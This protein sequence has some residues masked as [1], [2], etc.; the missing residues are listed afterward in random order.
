MTTQHTPTQKAAIVLGKRIDKGVM[1][2]NGNADWNESTKIAIRACNAHDEL[3]EALDAMLLHY[4]RPDK[5]GVVFNTIC[6][7]MARAAIA[8]A[9]KSP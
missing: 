2:I 7:A 8:K 1:R 5:N 6:A 4:T 3:V 9:T